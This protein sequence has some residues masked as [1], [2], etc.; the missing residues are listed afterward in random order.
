[1][2]FT[3]KKAGV[4]IKKAGSFIKKIN[5]LIRTTRRPE[6]IGDIGNFSGLFKIPSSRFG[7][8]LLVASADG[9]GTKLKVANILNKHNTV[10]IDLVAM[11]VNDIVTCGAEPLFFLDYF[12]AGKINPS[13]AYEIVKGIAA[14]CR[15]A[16]CALLGGETAE[17][18]GVYRNE[19]Y[20]LAGFCVGAVARDRLLTGKSI[21]AGDAVLGL[22]SS[23]LHSNGYSLVRK[24]FSA[25]EMRK[26]PS[27]FIR[28][29]II[30]VKPL[31]SLL[32]LFKLGGIAN[33][34]GGG[35]RDNIPRILPPG[36]GVEIQIDSWP[37]PRIF[38]LVQK[39]AELS[40]AEMFR[41][42]NMGVGMVL[43]LAAE[44]VNRAMRYLHS[45]FKLKSWVIGKVI[46]GKKM[47]IIR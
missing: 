45:K 38:K 10:G 43:I 35:F 5:P 2:V 47:V 31:R 16:G 29:T 28:P 34:T 30:Y 22:A 25:A 13:R 39:R 3:Y 20:D 18:P 23:G 46:S 4:D 6:V 36:C 40:D 37:I 12:A 9:V 44:S 24:L 15:Q 26:N 27:V 33:I 41:T 17:M 21:K 7:N 11:C 19:D 8:Q 14:G 32:N 1:M 42:F